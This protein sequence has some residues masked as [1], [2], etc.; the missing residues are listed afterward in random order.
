MQRVD[1]L[2]APAAVSSPISGAALAVFVMT[3]LTSAFLL[4]ALEPMF[5]KMLLPL[6]GGS[7]AVWNTAIVFFQVTLLAGYLYAH[8][9]RTR[10]SPLWQAIV[11]CGL[12]G[13]A[14]LTL[15]IAIPHWN[16]DPTQSPILTLLALAAIGVGLPF[17]VLS[18][19]SALIQAWFARSARAGEDPYTLFA[20][21]NLGSV[22]ALI[23]YPLSI[24]PYFGLSIQTRLWGGLFC[25][26]ALMI[27]ACAVITLRASGT[28]RAIAAP[29]VEDAG[30]AIPWKTVARWVA[31]AAV[32]SSLMLGATAFF[33]DKVAA[34][35]LL[36]TLP[37]GLYLITFVIAF[38]MSR[39]VSRALLARMIPV[40]VAIL[41]FVIVNEGDVSIKVSIAFH[42]F[43][44]FI[45]ALYCHATLRAERPPAGRLT[46]F[47]LWLA[48]GGALGGMFN[49]LVAP[50]VFPNV[51]EYQLALVGALL[52]L[53]RRA[54][55][56][57]MKHYISD[58]AAAAIFTVLL[59]G[60]ILVPLFT[61]EHL[62]DMA[63]TYAAAACV[64]LMFARRPLRFGL[65]VG[66]VFMLAAFM[67][68][69]TGNEIFR[70]RNFFGVKHVTRAPGLHRFIHGDTVHG[71]E[72]TLY[73]FE[74]EPTSYYSPSGG[75]GELFR[76]LGHR[77]DNA[78]IGVAGLGIGTAACY[79]RPGQAWTFY[80]IDPQVA[81]IANDPQYFRYLQLC[82]PNANIV[83]GDARLS[84]SREQHQ[85]YTVMILDAYTSDQMPVH[86]LTREA[87]QI[88][89]NA[90][91]PHGVLAFD[92]TNRYF[93]LRPVLGN[94]AAAN[95][96]V[97]YFRHDGSNAARVPGWYSSDWVVM[98]R[99]PADLAGIATD[100]RWQP[101]PATNRIPLW[102]DDYTSQIRILRASSL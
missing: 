88:Y 90:L 53:P 6:F 48:V 52:L 15:P 33:E 41:L 94:A 28:S 96:L 10:L 35:P 76:R 44:F 21:S 93:D 14:A 67:P 39:F 12:V 57:G 13:A 18:A 7:P 97:A 30:P 101:V 45:I 26:F 25:I 32:P 66:A 75:I 81:Q 34:I 77:L 56:P 89:M 47:Y 85:D 63:T 64:T 68:Y 19:N 69:W 24:E 38:G 2:S 84:L 80:E 62:A 70:T 99:N 22:A 59:G 73:S 1:R 98:A 29:P 3:V 20:A 55:P 79:A 16:G 42:L 31:L 8:F 23:A 37:L 72:S 11:H 36:W 71:I 46:E 92:I 54:G 27:L 82:Q 102:T 51:L 86:L 50:Q 74:R 65:A 95:G 40:A 78:R 91:A 49:A 60:F 5:T 87:F 83:L 58:V 100:S 61:D 43:V 4:F 9:L 17:F